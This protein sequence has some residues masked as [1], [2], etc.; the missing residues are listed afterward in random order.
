M[1]TV[2]STDKYLFLNLHVHI[3]CN[4]TINHLPPLYQNA[5]LW[6]NDIHTKNTVSENITFILN[7]FSQGKYAQ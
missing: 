4:Y 1:F 5:P 2:V 3:K 7:K 6:I